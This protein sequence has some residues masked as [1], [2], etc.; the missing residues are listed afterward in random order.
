VLQEG[1]A[2]FLRIDA[3]ETL[4]AQLA[5][6]AEDP[7]ALKIVERALKDLLVDEFQMGFFDPDEH[8]SVCRI[9]LRGRSRKE[10]P[11]PQTNGGKAIAPIH[12]N[13]DVDDPSEW[14]RRLLDFGLR[15]KINT[16]AEK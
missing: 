9:R 11:I 6:L 4:G 5:D 16:E 12:L 13:I 2:G 3:Q 8:D 7:T 10:V 14:V 1:S 15:Q